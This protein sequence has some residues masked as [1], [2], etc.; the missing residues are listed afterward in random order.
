MHEFIWIHF[1]SIYNFPW[2]PQY[3]FLLCLQPSVVNNISFYVSPRQPPSH[4]KRSVSFSSV[5]RG[6][7]TKPGFPW[8]LSCYYL[9]TSAFWAWETTPVVE[10]MPSMAWRDHVLT[11]PSLDFLVSVLDVCRQHYPQHPRDKQWLCWD[12]FFQKN[13]L[14]FLNWVSLT[15]WPRV[16][17]GLSLK[18]HKN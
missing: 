15:Q 14:C 16:M 4:S 10:D 11:H 13:N 8:A 2:D 3:N 7:V 18:T 6:F 12:S 9:T 5:F 17:S 1:E